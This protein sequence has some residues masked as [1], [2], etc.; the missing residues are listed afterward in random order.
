MVHGEN[1][2]RRNNLGCMVN[3]RE[4]RGVNEGHVKKKQCF[5]NMRYVGT[6]ERK[7]W[8][9]SRPSSLRSWVK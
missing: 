6:V 1:V 4:D 3:Y 2:V 9:D 5:G 8:F 7:M